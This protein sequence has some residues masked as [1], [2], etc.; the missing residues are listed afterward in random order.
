LWTW[1]LAAQFDLLRRPS[2]WRWFPLLYR[3]G[4]IWML[5]EHV[6]TL[7]GQS[8]FLAATTWTLVSAVCWPL[9]T[10]AWRNLAASMLRRC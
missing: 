2:L 6:V 3:D 4:L 5:N 10:T 8:R 7:R 1:E 9:Q